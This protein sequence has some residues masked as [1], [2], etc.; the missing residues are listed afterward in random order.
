MGYNIDFLGN[1]IYSEILREY[2]PKR[3]SEFVG[4]MGAITVMPYRTMSTHNDHAIN[5]SGYYSPPAK[6]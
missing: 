1:N 5:K 4:T 3:I 2:P 6:K